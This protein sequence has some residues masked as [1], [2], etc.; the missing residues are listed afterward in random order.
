MQTSSK[1]PSSSPDHNPAQVLISDPPAAIA[2]ALAKVSLAL[3]HRAWREA[4]PRELTPTQGQ[5][6]TFLDQRAGASL[7]EVAE[8]LGIR[9]STASEAVATLVQKDLLERHRDP[10]DRRRLRLMLSARGRREA[11]TTALWPDFLAAA[12]GSLSAEEQ[13]VLVRALQKMI[14]SLIEK[15]HIPTAEM[16]LR[17]RYFRPFVHRDTP[18]P[19]HCA[20]VDAP[21]AESDLRFACPEQITAD[22]EQLQQLRR[23]FTV[24]G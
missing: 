10:A 13:A 14:S 5:V 15:G 19:H 2:T 12:V 23:V 9:D 1:D 24:G 17:C 16:C 7:G 18:R 21:M 11:A 3:R 8:A 22:P 4:H 6:L 20:F